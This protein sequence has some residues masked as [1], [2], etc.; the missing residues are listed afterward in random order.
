MNPPDLSQQLI[1]SIRHLIA[2]N[3][4]KASDLVP[5]E[6]ATATF[7]TRLH[8]TWQFVARAEEHSTAGGE[9]ADRHFDDDITAFN[10]HTDQLHLL[11][12]HDTILRTAFLQQ[13]AAKG[14][15][16]L[17][18]AQ[19]EYRFY[20]FHPFSVRKNCH[21]CKGTGQIAC[22]ACHGRGSTSCQHCHGRGKTMERLPEYDAQGQYIGSKAHSKPCFH[23]Q[24]GVHT[25]STCS[26]NGHS[27]CSH[28]QG[29]G[30]FT[31]TRQ[32]IAYA[33]PSF[34]I[35]I[36]SKHKA[37]ELQRFL[38]RQSL[39]FC[40]E[41]IP[42]ELIQHAPT[43]A[44]S[45]CFTYQGKQILLKQEF[46]LKKRPYTCYALAQ[47]PHPFIRPHLFDDL[48]SDELQFLLQHN[49][50]PQCK[51]AKFFNRYAKQP[52]LAQAMQN[53]N[54]RHAYPDRKIAVAEACQYFISPHM[55]EQIALALINI[56]NKVSPTYAK[57]WW[58]AITALTALFGAFYTEYCAEV[59]FAHD[60]FR[61]I[62]NVSLVVLASTLAIGVFTWL[63]SLAITAF[64]NRNIPQAYQQTTYHRK[65]II[66]LFKIT[67][68][69]HL[70]ALLYGLLAAQT[71]LPSWQGQ[72]FAYGLYQTEYYCLQHR[73]QPTTLSTFCP[74]ILQTLPNFLGLSAH[75]LIAQQE[76][77]YP[78]QTT[79][80]KVFYIQRQLILAG[81]DIHMDGEYGA[82]TAAYSQEYLQKNGT[83]KVSP[84]IDGVY[85]QMGGQ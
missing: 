51:A 37:T 57:P 83:K 80:D 13:M 31:I 75:E 30:F 21:V 85:R 17:N 49:I 34:H 67:L 73:T 2:G 39:T 59:L 6:Y 1:D 8:L 55:A 33:V 38:N 53:L 47:P 70:F 42:F 10:Y 78:A 50:S 45:H 62:G 44:N 26:G 27:A 7:H 18:E 24:N 36:A 20:T 76:Q 14:K 84:H 77:N 9:V 46:T 79:Q 15:D 11:A 72:P 66:L 29:H 5:Q 12:A 81:Y 43:T 63:G 23:C 60:L 22:R 3:Q 58:Y 74:F 52:V 82:Q 35:Q 40:A 54:A 25:C 19:Q 41:K 32:L 65:P 16:A 69:S 61:H 28:C 56:M 68:L 64:R 71:W 48:L 4:V